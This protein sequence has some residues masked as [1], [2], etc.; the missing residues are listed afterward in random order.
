MADNTQLN[1]GTGGDTIATDDIGGVKHQ[2]VKIEWGVDG[3]ATPTSAAN[4]LPVVQTGTPTLP[5]GAATAAN[6]QTDALTDTQLRA[7][8]VGV[9]TELTTA[10]LDTGAGTDTRAV[11]GLVGSKSGGAVL[12]PGDATKGL[13]VDLSATGAN[14]NKFL[15][16]PDL[17]TGASTAAKQDTGNTSLSSIDGK[18]TAVNTGAVVVSSSALPSGAAT[19]AKQP[20]LGT[21]GTSSADVITVQGRTSM[22]PLL[23][24]GSATTQ[25]VSGTVTVNAGTNL[26]TSALALAATQTDKSQFTKLTDGTDTALITAAGEQNVIATAQPGVDIGDVTVNNSTGAAAVNIQDGG[27]SLT[28]DYATTGSGTATGALR[29]ELPTNGTG[30]IATVGAVTAITNPLPAGTNAIG[31]LAANSGVD[32][33]DVDIT[34]VNPG[35]GATSLG[36]AEDAVHASGDTMVYVGGV[37]QDADTSPVSNDGDYHG[38]IFNAVGRAKVS[39]LPA[40]TTTTTGNITTNTGTITVDC[41]RQSGVTFQI[42]GTFAGFNATFEASIDGGTTYNAVAAARS[43]SNM[44][45]L[46]TGVL[47]ANPG[48]FW[49]IAAF[50]A[51]NVRMRATALVSGTV[52]VVGMPTAFASDPAPVTQQTAQARTTNP[53]AF[54][55]GTAASVISD[56]VGRQVVI[57]NQ[58]RDLVTQNVVTLTSTTTETT[59]LAAGAA[60]VFHDLTYLKFT[61][62]SATGT[63]VTVRD[64]TAGTAVDFW[65]VPAGQTVGGILQTPFKQTT[66]ANNW[67]VQCTTSVDSVYVTAQAAKNI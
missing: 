60:G 38:F 16:T 54:S 55:D 31:K 17:P 18:I 45:D 8:S 25:P 36:K 2:Q 51:T 44:I 11:V 57:A 9:D 13:A 48:Y 47:S 27:N 56:K 33:G 30:V 28:V 12:I 66:A 32:I 43:N 59:L 67:T 4:P 26:N 35:T 65:Y 58:V 62:K 24:D 5:T 10:D 63:L 49:R 14:T 52:A 64:A 40:A 3:T 22:T 50:N 20:A 42:T 19:S 61:N 53:T 29:V 46:T 23:T 37:R 39:S 34:S 6:Q 7:S 21:A 41:T 15:V 1:P